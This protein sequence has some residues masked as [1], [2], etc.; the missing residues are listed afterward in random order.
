MQLDDMATPVNSKGETSTLGNVNGRKFTEKNKNKNEV[1]EI[2]TLH[3]VCAVHG[4]CSVH[5]A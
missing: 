5:W 2:H 3:N 4:E 1:E